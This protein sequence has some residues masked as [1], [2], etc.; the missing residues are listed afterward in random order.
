MLDIMEPT[1][2]DQ[3]AGFSSGAGCTHDGGP[4]WISVPIQPDCEA[5]VVARFFQKSKGPKMTSK[6]YHSRHNNLHYAQEKQGYSDEELVE[7]LAVFLCNTEACVDCDTTGGEIR[8]NGGFNAGHGGGNPAADF[9]IFNPN[10]DNN[11]GE[12]N[13]C[14][15]DFHRGLVR[16]EE[17]NCTCDEDAYM[18][19]DGDD[20]VCEFGYNHWK[21]RC[22]S[23]DRC[24]NSRETTES[25]GHSCTCKYGR[26]SGNDTHSTGH[27]YSAGGRCTGFGMSTNSSWECSC[28]SS[29]G[30]TTRN[31]GNNAGNC[32]CDA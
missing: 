27:C 28:D 3:P 9:G 25:N 30:F 32:R 15:C 1:R 21:Y 26:S 5:P 31:Q 8:V 29:A 16:D 11:V 23:E 20:C 6:D 12:N 14:V 2:I 4:L 19:T 18:V 17:G 13:I 22:N 7:C 10:Y 24:T